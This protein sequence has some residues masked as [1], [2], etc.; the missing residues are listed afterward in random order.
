MYNDFLNIKRSIL[1]FPETQSTNNDLK[2]E[3]RKSAEPVFAVIRAD[4]QAGGRGR[5]GRT[6][7]SPDGGLYFSASFPLCGKETNIPFLTL[8]AGLAA[9]EAIDELTNSETRIKWPNDIYLEDKKLGGILCELVSGTSLCAVVGIGI[10]I[11]TSKED[12]PSDIAETATSLSVCRITPP[13]KNALMM[14]IIQRLDYL[15]YEN[16]ELFKTTDK[17]LS[18]IKKRS[19]SIGK[20]VRYSL[21]D[22]VIEG[23]ITDI[24]STGAA[25]I[26]SEDKSI[27]EIFCGEIV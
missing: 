2:S 27:R 23:I 4:K 11:D 5:L 24:K 12:F 25:Q 19:Y 14:K 1:H 22:T 7:I 10:N 21:G 3:I 17:T 6:F 13:D 26:T 15:I 8:L 9:S 16:R 18:E 20:K